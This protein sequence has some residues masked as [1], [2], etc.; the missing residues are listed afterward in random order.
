[1][2][3]AVAFGARQAL[4]GGGRVLYREFARV[5]KPRFLFHESDEKRYITVFERNNKIRKITIIYKI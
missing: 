3:V 5:L 2:A 1:M 4:D